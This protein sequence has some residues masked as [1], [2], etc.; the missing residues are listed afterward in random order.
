MKLASIKP[1][2]IVQIDKKGRRFL[3]IVDEKVERG[4]KVKP[5]DKQI[6]WH[7]AKSTEVITHWSKRTTPTA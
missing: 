3:A 5:L 1:G 7:D 6:T 4:L 2:D